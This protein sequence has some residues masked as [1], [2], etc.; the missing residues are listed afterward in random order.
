MRPVRSTGPTR[1]RQKARAAA[2]LRAPARRPV[3]VVD[4][5]PRARPPARAGCSGRSACPRRRRLRQRPASRGHDG[6]PADMASRTG[7]PKPSSSD[8]QDQHA[9]A[10]HRTASRCVVRH[11]SE[12]D[13]ASRKRRRARGARATR[14]ASAVACPASTSRGSDGIAA[15]ASRTRRAARRCS[16]AAPACRRTGCIRRR[17]VGPDARG[18]A[19]RSV[20]ASTR[21]SGPSGTER[22]ADQ[23]PSR[24]GRGDD[25]IGALA[26]VG[27]QRRVVAPDLRACAL[28]MDRKNRSW[29]VTIWAASRAGMQQRV[30]RVHDVGWA[31][32]GLDR[33]PFGPVPEQFRTRT[34]IAAVDDRPTPSSAP[35]PSGGRSFHELVKTATGSSCS[36]PV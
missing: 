14:A 8:G 13:G 2:G 9:S 7:S 25:R 19:I 29:M 27:R 11:V 21:R 34:G 12:M 32:E 26:C 5:T 1:P 24:P 20:Q 18:S 31:G 3:I 22:F 16:C 28:G 33:R 4:Q 17:D 15:A 35:S 36:A 10:R 23:P 30:R 6:M